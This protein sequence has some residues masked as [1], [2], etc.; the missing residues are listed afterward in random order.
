[1]RC[2]RLMRMPVRTGPSVPASPSSG[3]SAGIVSVFM[4]A[5]DRRRAVAR[6]DELGVGVDLAEVQKLL[7]R[8]KRRRAVEL[9]GGQLDEP[10]HAE[11]GHHRGLEP[12]LLVGGNLVQR[13]DLRA[14]RPGGELLEVHR[15]ENLVVLGFEQVKSGSSVVDHGGGR[16]TANRGAVPTGIVQRSFLVGNG[17]F[18]THKTDEN[19]AERVRRKLHL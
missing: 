3:S 10:V 2:W 7:E 19:L 17:C 9:V 8:A 5:H 15:P 18:V 16:R 11:F 4:L 14:G 12:R 13:R 1:M 6:V